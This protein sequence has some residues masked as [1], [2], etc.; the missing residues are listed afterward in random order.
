MFST[1]V[2]NIEFHRH[3]DL[4]ANGSGVPLKGGLLSNSAV[5]DGTGDQVLPVGAN[6]NALIANSGSSL[7][8]AWLPA[9]VAAAPF[10]YTLATRTLTIATATNSVAGVLSAADHTTFSG[11]AAS[12][13]LKANIASPTFTGVVTIPTP[14]TLGA[15]SVTATGTQMNFLVGVTSAIQTQLNAKA[16]LASPVFTGDVNVSTGNLLIST[17]GKGLQIKTG[18]NAKIGTAVLAAGTVTVLNSSVT[19]NS[20]IFLTAQTNSGTTGALSISAKVVGTSFT[21]TSL[22]ALDTSTVAWM[23]VESIP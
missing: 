22:S 13:A 15:V 7:G 11:Y 21:I 20:R 8:L 16:P 23:I 4:I 9:V 14:F 18:T 5:N 19:A 12:I 6:G 3:V 10:T 1:T 17:I 2:L